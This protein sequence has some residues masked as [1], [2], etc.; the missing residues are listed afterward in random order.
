MVDSR[1]KGE[2]EKMLPWSKG[3]YLESEAE[4]GED[5]CIGELRKRDTKHLT[6]NQHMARCEGRVR[7]GQQTKWAA[8]ENR[9][10]TCDSRHGWV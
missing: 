5:R 1:R 3:A 8:E 2:W 10:G 9:Q 6:E 4:I 7:R